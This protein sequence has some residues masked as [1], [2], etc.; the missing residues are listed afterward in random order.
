MAN[1]AILYIYSNKGDASESGHYR[2]S[3]IPRVVYN[4][5]RGIVTRELTETPHIRT[6]SDQYGY[7]GG[8]SA[9]DAIASSER[10]VDYANRDA[11]IAPVGAPKA[12]GTINRTLQ[13]ETLC[14]QG[15]PHERIKQIRRCQKGTKLA[16]KYRENMESRW[17]QYRIPPTIRNKC[18][19]IRKLHG[20]HSHRRLE[21]STAH[22]EYYKNDRTDRGKQL[23]WEKVKP[24]G[25]ENL[26]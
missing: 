26:F 18:D 16:P 1:A 19:T 17:K 10:Y 15:P 23:L 5:R 12:R 14:R 21:E 13:W 8:L 7:M 22:P 9:I 4:I 24:K 11:E 25:R 3:S 6:R 20:R 2:P